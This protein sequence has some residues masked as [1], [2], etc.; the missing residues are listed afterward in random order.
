MDVMTILASP[1]PNGNT[2][3]VLDWAE[4]ALREHKHAVERIHLNPLD[5]KDC[6]ACLACAESPDKPGCVI[7]DDVPVVLDRMIGGNAVVFAS[8]L[9]MWGVTGPLKMLYDRCLCLVRGWGTTEHRS[10]GE[11]LRMA[12]LITCAGGEGDNTAPVTTTFS[13]FARFLKADDRGSYVFPN[14]TEPGRLPNTHGALARQLARQ[15]A[16]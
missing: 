2:E 9:Y 16:E 6:A 13:R 8:P 4:R 15:L 3:R 14:C 1:R 5:V 11:G 12:Q 7:Q 10:F